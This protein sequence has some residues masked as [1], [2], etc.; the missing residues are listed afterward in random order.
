MDPEIRKGRAGVFMQRKE[1]VQ[2]RIE[3][4]WVLPNAHTWQ[5]LSHEDSHLTIY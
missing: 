3:G 4:F 2:G 1:T 5:F